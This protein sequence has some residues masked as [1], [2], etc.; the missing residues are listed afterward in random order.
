VVPEPIYGATTNA[1]VPKNP[2]TEWRDLVD[3][4]ID[5][6]RAKG[7]LRAALVR[8]LEAVGVPASMVPPQLLF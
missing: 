7:E 8:N 3:T 4:W 2:N 5:R 6:R 1:I